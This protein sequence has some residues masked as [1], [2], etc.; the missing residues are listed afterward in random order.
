MQLIRIVN[1][2]VF[3]LLHHGIYRAIQDMETITLLGLN[4]THVQS[5]SP[6]MLQRLNMGAPIESMRLPVISP[7]A[8][9]HQVMIKLDAVQGIKLLEDLKYLSNVWNPSVVP[10]LG[11]FLVSTRM[12]RGNQL[13]FGWLN[14]TANGDE[15]FSQY[16]SHSYY[17]IGPALTTLK[18]PISSNVFKNAGDPRMILLNPSTIMIAFTSTPVPFYP[19]R[20]G[21]LVLKANHT[22]KQLELLEEYVLEPTWQADPDAEKSYHKNWSPFIYN[23]TSVLWA[24]SLDPLV[25][26]SAYPHETQP[27]VRKTR[28]VSEAKS[29]AHWNEW[30][31]MRGGTSGVL[32]SKHRYL[33]F[34]HS[35][36]HLPNNQRTTYFFGAFICSASPPFTM[37]HI[38][39]S[40][41]YL[42]ELYDGAWDDIKHFDYVVYPMSLHLHENDSNRLSLLEE[43][44]YRCLLQYNATL[45]LGWQDRSGIISSINL[46][47]LVSTMV[48]LGAPGER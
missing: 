40:P 16:C 38:S 41:V 5:F 9:L 46:G 4:S 13:Y 42:R 33:F 24:E 39:R 34:F 10:F 6:E 18:L 2:T 22:S 3:Y 1:S 27:Y 37:T 26:L 29:H 21:V 28:I 25:V 8:V 11:K 31:T 30:G 43:C 12:I 36:I 20:V 19:S 32:I 45:L 47:K 7:D 44:D 23:N 15:D 14:E 48:E 35:R 17:G